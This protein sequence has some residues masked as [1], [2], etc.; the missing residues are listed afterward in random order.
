MLGVVICLACLLLV[1][2]L[3]AGVAT[4]LLMRRSTHGPWEVDATVTREY[5]LHNSG[6]ATHHWNLIGQLRRDRRTK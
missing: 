5:Q 4:A 6:N 3:W 2:L 1:V